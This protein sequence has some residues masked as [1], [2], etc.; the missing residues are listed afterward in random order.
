M[1]NAEIAKAYITIVPSMKGFRETVQ[2]EIPG[3]TDPASKAAGESGGKS[4]GSAFGGAL[5]GIAVGITAALGT[6]VAGVVSLT[7]EAIQNYS[8]YEQ[9][10]GGAQLMFGD[11]FETVAKYASDAY[12]TV[13]MSQ[14]DYLQQVN[15]F[16]T[17]LKTA[18][19][20]DAEAAAELANRIVVAEADVVAATGNSQEAV[21]NAFNGIMRSNFTMLDNLQLGITPTKEGFQEV[22]DKVNEWNA[23]NGR[24]TN[25]QM[26]NLADMQSALVDYIEMQGLAGYASNEAADT[27]Q[28]SLSTLSAS[29]NNLVTGLG[30]SSQDLGPLI[31]NVVDSA[32]TVVNN[33]KPI[34]LQAV[35]GL[36]TLI[37]E[38][39]PILVAE[40]PTLINELVP[41][42]LSSATQV[43]MAV[44]TALPSLLSMIT[45]QIPVIL[46]SLIPALV[47]A[48]PPIFNMLV[49]AIL[50]II[51]MAPQLIEAGIQIVVS[52]INGISDAI[53][54][55]LAMIP[56]LLTSLYTVLTDNLGVI[57]E[58]GVNLLMALVE[59]LTETIPQIIDQMPIICDLLFDAVLNNLP[60]LISA[61][62]NLIVALVNGVVKATPKIIALMPKLIIQLVQNLVEN[63]PQIIEAGADIIESLVNGVKSLASNIGEVGAD[64]IEWLVDAL[65]GIPDK[66]FSIGKNVV[67]GLWNGINDMKSWVLNKIKSLGNSVVSSIKSALGIHSPST[68][69]RDQVGKNIA[70]GIGEGFSSE[71]KDVQ[72][73]MTAEMDDLTFAMNGDMKAVSVSDS[74]IVPSSS[75]INGGNISI[76]VYG[77]EG[78]DVNS[79]AEI[80]AQ[81]LGDMTRRKELAYA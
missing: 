1:A 30:D 70:L 16:A 24:A 42:L 31:Q 48:L 59:G 77:A 78:Q 18:L 4:F 51:M 58:A 10:V 26:G 67:K 37:T 46:N 44:V 33:I 20:G 76:N 11:A 27:I 25:Y 9:L 13:Q 45:T 75:T 6:A 14:N 2:K 12:K 56:D 21:Q 32:L 40:L 61:G 57:I 41:A 34:A 5:K 38:A 63:F 19:G 69:F 62:I 35:Q 66:L 54:Q 60:T 47:T 39:T 22:I 52:L 8:E 7:K 79:L 64:I 43:V 74:A 80:I 55:L 3:A 73:E 72:K 49:D 68:V 81:K 29:W 53:P 23:A 15:G 28:G 50:Q 71:M 36:S 65:D 17:G